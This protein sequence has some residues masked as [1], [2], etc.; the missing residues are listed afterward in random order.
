MKFAN[1]A[2]TFRLLI[3]AVH[4]SLASQLSLT[5][6]L[7]IAFVNYLIDLLDGPIAR[8]FG[9]TSYGGF[10]DLSIDRIVDISYLAYFLTLDRISLGFFV[11]LTARHIFYDFA[12]HFEMV[13]KTKQQQKDIMSKV[14]KL[15]YTSGASRILNAFAKASIVFFGFVSGVPVWLQVFFLGWTYVRAMPAIIRV[16]KLL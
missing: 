6:N 5:A 14:H 4:L 7:T 10:L 16:F 13:L 1:T 15:I 11:L 2:S 12:M 3:L 8:K 9:S